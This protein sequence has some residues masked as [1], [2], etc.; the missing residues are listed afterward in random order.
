M[1]WIHTI[2]YDDSS[3]ELRQLYDR[4]KGPDNNVD[5]V[6]LTMSCWRTVCACIRC[7]VT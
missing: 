4:V 2:S 6:M 3:G 5:N 1:T 7:R